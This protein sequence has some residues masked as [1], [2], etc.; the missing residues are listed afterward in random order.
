MDPSGIN[1]HKKSDP[2][3]EGI[4][5]RLVAPHPDV[6]D[7]GSR[8]QARLLSTLTLGLSIITGITAIFSTT[9]SIE[10]DARAM[11]ILLFVLVGVYGLSRSQHFRFGAVLLVMMSS[12]LGSIGFMDGVAPGVS[13]FFFVPF[14]Y[15]VAVGILPWQAIGLISL[16]NLSVPFVLLAFSPDLGASYAWVAV[17]QIFVASALSIAISLVNEKIGQSQVLEVHKA[18][19]KLQELNAY[20]EQRV[21]E[22]TRD[23]TMAAEVGQKINQSLDPVTMLDEAV[24]LIRDHFRL[25]HVQVY[26]VDATGRNLILKASTGEAGKAM[27]ERGHRLPVD[28]TS[29]NGTAAVERRMVFVSNTR[30]SISFRPNPLLPETHSELAIPLISGTRV[31]GVLD[32]QSS[33][34]ELLA[35]ENH[36]AFESL[37]GQLSTAL[38]NAELFAQTQRSMKEIETRTRRS[39]RQGWAKYLN[40][41]D[42][43]DRIAYQF[44]LLGVHPVSTA[45]SIESNPNIVNIPIK[46]SGQSLGYFAL[47]G[48][49]PWSG[50]DI[51]LIQ[52][53]AE[54]VGHQIENVRLLSQAEQY[55]LEAEAML[56]RLTREGWEASLDENNISE[57]AYLY[58]DGQVHLLSSYGG[59]ERNGIS[60]EIKVQDEAI[61]ELNFIGLE[62]L[63]EEDA[64]LVT[65]ISEQLGS[66]LEN[67]RLYTDAQRELFERERIER[68]L[69]SQRRTLQVVLDNMPV[70]VLMVEA[71]S[72]ETLLANKQAEHLVGNGIV[73]LNKEAGNAGLFPIYRRGTDEVY[74]VEAFPGVTSM[75]GIPASVD[76]IEV[77]R[78]D[79]SLLLLQINGSPIFDPDGHV[80]AT[81]SVFQDIT[82]DRQTQEIIAKRAVE[83]AMVAE[84]ATR[85][86]SVQ[87][88]TEMLQT[89]VDMTRQAFDLYHVHIYLLDDTG[90]LLVLAV[91]SGEIGRQMVS[92][93]RQIALNAEKSL[94]ARAAR[95]RFGVIVNNVRQD[96]GFLPHRLLPNTRSELAVPMIVGDQLSGVLDIQDDET[97]R[98]TSEDVN[99]MTTLAAQVA[100]SLQNARSFIRAQ[101]QA[102]REALINTIGERIQATNSVEAALQV[103]VREIGRAMGAQ[104][105]SI[106]L[107]IN[108]SLNG[109]TSETQNQLRA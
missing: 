46:I 34:P 50:E 47:A 62:R 104:A 72:G 85:V 64:E 40:A 82:R 11:V 21:R 93:D 75:K 83:L 91:G 3:V 96:P 1:I 5:N 61:G 103:A 74:P 8:Q 81:V 63:L 54:Q 51:N 18:N 38:V 48:D 90:E 59:I 71:S 101:R 49:H 78:P 6:V 27:L 53:V 89:V 52:E 35:V 14:T 37:T 56:R 4:W 24:S 109:R 9:D 86:A 92:E 2:E 13:V 43:K 58:S 36:P 39:V 106:R 25:Y 77:R 80:I 73:S 29:L 55:R 15:L 19:Q 17:T 41:L 99:I 33:Q 100:V 70:G 44:D 76:D 88:P 65:T 31:L 87:N 98:F 94:V 28:V 7:I 84:V 57:Q 23:I 20:L 107:G 45:A 102:E 60:R 67:L 97:G 30:T 66:H 95:T 105:T 42:R 108:D 16:V 32:L 26:L 79:G 69:E 10:V 68:D 12:F 22:Q